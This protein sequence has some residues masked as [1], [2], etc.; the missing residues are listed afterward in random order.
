MHDD[1]LEDAFRR[2]LSDHADDLRDSGGRAVTAHSAVRRRR[3]RQALAITA[4][5]AVLV[6]GAGAWA[7]VAQPGDSGAATATHR[8]SE[9]YPRGWRIESYDGIELRVPASWG[10]GWTPERTDHG[11]AQ[12]HNRR[13]S[14]PTSSIEIRP[15]AGGIEVEPYVG[16][17]LLVRGGC[18][19]SA[20]TNAAHVWFGSPLPVGSDPD[21]GVTVRVDG[22]TTF[23][24]T[25]YDGNLAEQ[26]EIL[27]TIRPVVTDS[28]GCEPE[29]LPES[30][31]RNLDPANVSSISVCVYYGGGGLPE[32]PQPV[33]PPFLFYSTLVT[34]DA[35]TLAAAI[36][37]G[38][39]NAGGGTGFLF[40]APSLIRLVEHAAGQSSVYSLNP[41]GIGPLTYQGPRAKHL[42]TRA[43][44]E[45][46]AVDGAGLYTAGAPLH[47]PLTRL[48]PPG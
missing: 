31:G 38:P 23:K 4:A 41:Q 20:F 21:T 18:V 36:E 24:I 6:G 17:P 5:V 48:L 34:G 25:V 3:R 42:V 22:L 28:N 40:E 14:K 12:C 32:Q 33:Q 46:W 16:R 15:P 45:L 11:L 30:P 8:T 39:G 29:V 47:N 35:S 10:W 26:Q 44:V 43:S 13:Y 2:A 37:S 19:R 27:H 7:V 9:G 1:E